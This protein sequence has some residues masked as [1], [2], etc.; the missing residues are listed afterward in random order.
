MSEV[1][2]G[3]C[4]TEILITWVSIGRIMGS[5][6]VN[7]VIAG[8]IASS[9]VMLV[10]AAGVRPFS[11]QH[12]Q[13]ASPLAK[14]EIEY[15]LEG[16]IFPPEIT[17]PTFLWHDRS[18]TAKRWVVEVSFAGHSKSIRVESAGEFMHVGESDPQAGDAAIL[19][20]SLTDAR[21]WKPDSETW[22]KIKQLSVKSPAT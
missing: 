2:R 9:S 15:P 12:A 19:I 18:E 10:C 14:V 22:N 1:T 21:T 17:P 3:N 5:R 20:P 7:F 11:D 6:F 8:A 13:A 4:L 16:S